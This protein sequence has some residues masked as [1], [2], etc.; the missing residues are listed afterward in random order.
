MAK[1]LAEV[2]I[3]ALFFCAAP[4]MFASH[5][6]LIIMAA[7]LSRCGHYIFILRFLLSFFLLPPF[8]PRLISAVADRMS[9]TPPHMVWP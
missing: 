9:T 3:G 4:Y 5:I 6:R 1:I 8:L 7:L 2:R